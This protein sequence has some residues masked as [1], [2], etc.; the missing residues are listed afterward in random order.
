MKTLLAF[1]SLVVVLPVQAALLTNT[2]SLGPIG[3][4]DTDPGVPFTFNLGGAFSSIS[5]VT[6]VFDP[7]DPG[8]CADTIGNAE[9]VVLMLGSETFVVP[10][11]GTGSTITAL[12]IFSPALQSDFLDG[13]VSGL[14]WLH[15]QSGV[16]FDAGVSS[17][18]ITLLVEGAPASSVPE[19]A[20]AALLGFGLALLTAAYR[21][22][23]ARA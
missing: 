16:V 19:P 20:S 15:E 22:R 23:R 11:F 21:R 10:S 4:T 2:Q 5:S 7:C 17:A 13:V 8:A 6:F 1:L 14:I 3:D 12:L 9:N 18:D